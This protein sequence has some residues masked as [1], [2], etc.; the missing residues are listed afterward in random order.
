MGKAVIHKNPTC[1]SVQRNVDEGSE[2][3]AAAGSF[4]RKLAF[5]A[6]CMWWGWQFFTQPL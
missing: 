3:L 5:C 6:A 4:F 2:N 1:P